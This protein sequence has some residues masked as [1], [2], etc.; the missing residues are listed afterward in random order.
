MKI[1]MTETSI[2]P[3]VFE[4]FV[5]IGSEILKDQVIGY[6]TPSGIIPEM[7]LLSGLFSASVIE[8]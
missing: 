5:T 6:F 4:A 2:I 1:E 7:P 8:E 3:G